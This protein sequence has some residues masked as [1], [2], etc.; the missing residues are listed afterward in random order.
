[1]YFWLPKPTS[2]DYEGRMEY[3]TTKVY[4]QI[5]WR[6]WEFCS[7]VVT[8]IQIIQFSLRSNHSHILLQLNSK[9]LCYVILDR[10]WKGDIYGFFKHNSSVNHTDNCS[11]SSYYI[12]HLST[13]TLYC[14]WA[15][16]IF[17]ECSPWYIYDY[18]F[19]GQ[20][21]LIC[22]HLLGN[23]H[24]SWYSRGPFCF[25]EL[26]WILFSIISR[27]LEQEK[28]AGACVQVTIFSQSK[29]ITTTINYPLP[30]LFFLLPLHY[31]WYQCHHYYHYYLRVPHLLN[32]TDAGLTLTVSRILCT[33][34]IFKIPHRS[35]WW[36]WNTGITIIYVLKYMLKRLSGFLSLTYHIM[37]D[38]KRL[39]C[40]ICYM[41]IS[42]YFSQS[43]PPRVLWELIKCIK[44]HWCFILLNFMLPL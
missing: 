37:F 16:T 38:L 1:M 8:T 34:T 25:P 21:S 43:Y 10:G 26:L 6:S 24:N 36:N 2:S 42:Q 44:F 3:H 39:S 5:F 41:V 35:R 9:I 32:K 12:P 13:S 4:K 17:Y 28:E 29:T 20:S 18:G 31:Y 33:E 19:L 22:I 15:A 7:S 30:T 40:Y 23:T 14:L 27:D 11:H